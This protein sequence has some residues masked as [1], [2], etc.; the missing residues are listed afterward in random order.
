VVTVIAVCV[1]GLA[2][3]A[4]SAGATGTG[5]VG[6]PH[7]PAQPVEL[8][9]GYSDSADINDRG[10]TV[11]WFRPDPTDWDH[12]NAFRRTARGR[13]TDLGPG[14]AHAVNNHG[15]AVGE[16]PDENWALHAIRWNAN[17]RAHDLG[18]GAHSWASDI[19]DRGV[20]VGYL[21]TPQGHRAFVAAPGAAPTLLPHPAGIVQTQDIAMAI[22][23]RGDIA[24]FSV[25]R[26]TGRLNP[27]VWRG[28]AHRPTLL[29]APNNYYHSVVGI[30]EEGTVV[31][32]REAPGGYQTVIWT[33]RDHHE[34]AI[35]E[36]GVLG[37][38]IND[39]GQVA[40]VR[41][42]ISEV[43]RWDPRTGE[44]TTLV[45][46]SPY[47]WANG[48]NNAG[49]VVGHSIMPDDFYSHATLFG[50]PAS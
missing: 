6:H 18:A 35:S 8:L 1:G 34:V 19:N 32:T 26:D 22:N 28:R 40:G 11:G 23:E 39:R 43:V 10:V 7:P 45:G 33:G 30:N 3:P 42:D 15:V 2:P 5:T 9:G 44:T 36:P 46:L 37:W 24:G 38:A 47:G 41:S 31:G 25:D 49:A 14:F 21:T 4:A 13:V 48:M 29:P 12:Y 20:I 27:V 50:E 16:R 17:G